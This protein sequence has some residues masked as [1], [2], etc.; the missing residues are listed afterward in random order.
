MFSYR[1]R[2]NL[3]KFVTA[4][5]WVAV[6]CA[7]LFL[8]W[9]LWL[10]RFIVYT[11]DGAKLN[12]DQ[13]THF[14]QGEIALRPTEDTSVNIYFDEGN[15]QPDVDETELKQLSGIYLTT[16][17]LL[18]KNFDATA[19]ALKD[20]P[21]GS[22]ILLEVKSIH[23]RYYYNTDMGPASTDIPTD[24][25][26]QLI[27]QLHRSGHY[28]I[29]RLPAFRDYYYA[30]DNVSDGIYLA[31]KRGLWLDPQRTYWLNPAKETTLTYLRD[32]VTE[33]RLLGFDEVVLSDFSIPDTQEIFFDGDRAET[34]QKAAEALAKLSSSTF[35]VSF[36]V[37]D[38]TFP[39][40]E[41]RCRLYFA[42][43]PAANAASTAIA[44]GIL[45]T[46]KRIVFLTD[47]M[48][49]RYDAYGVLRPLKLEN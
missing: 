44:T 35:A 25:L 8:C 39:L 18:S 11:R 6:L 21:A 43:V 1:F 24:K 9:L 41:G 42:D 19:Q 27:A 29:A 28:L 17:M 34:I 15:Q 22:T 33:L 12:F 45:D 3:R 7:A 10:N 40:P 48:D 32:T 5:F 16:D 38:P 23:G 31:S 14:P 36:M 13:D 46:D 37:S 26:S 30:L 20:L 47:L 4:L 49:T 2:H